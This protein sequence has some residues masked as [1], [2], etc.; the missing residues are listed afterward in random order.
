MN[1]EQKSKTL[2]IAEA[3]RKR[4]GDYALP[5]ISEDDEKVLDRAW[6]KVSAKVGAMVSTKGQEENIQSETTSN[7]RQLAVVK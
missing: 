3:A 2:L 1:I 6:A 5:E 4:R 7:E